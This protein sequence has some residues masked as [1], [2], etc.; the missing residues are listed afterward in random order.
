MRR[1]IAVLACLTFC[2]SLFVA[3]AEARG[4]AQAD[5]RFGELRPNTQM[6]PTAGFHVP[7][8]GLR[9]AAVA[10]TTYLGDWT[11]DSGGSIVPDGWVGVDLTAQSGEFWHVDDFAGLGGG[12]FGG[13]LP[14][15]GSQSM[16]CGA[17]AATTGPT[18][19]YSNA[20]GYG[21]NWDQVFRST[22]FTSLTGDLDLS[23]LASWDSEANWDFTYLEYD[24]CDDSWV[25]LASFDNAV[26]DSLVTVTI[27]DS[28]HAGSV[29]VRFRFISDGNTDDE[30]GGWN[31]DGPFI[32]DSL[33]VGD[34][35]GEVSFENFEVESV[36]DQATASGDWFQENLMSYGDFAGVY[37]GLFQVNESVCGRDL[38]G[39]WGFFNGSTANYACGGFPAQATVPYENIRG[40]YL[41]NEIWSPVVPFV[42]SGTEVHLTFRVYR[43]L[44]VDAL[45]FYVWN[46][47]SYVGGES[48]CPGSW[49]SD[50][51]V[52]YGP[53][54]DWL[55][56]DY[57]EPGGLI[58]PGATH[59]QVS[60]GCYDMCPYWCGIYGTGNCHSHSPLVDDVR[61]LRINTSGPQ[62]ETR[63]WRFFQDNFASDGTTTGTVRIDQANDIL[64][65]SNPNIR[66]GDSTLVKVNDPVYGL[67][68]D[69]YTS[70]GPAVYGWVSVRP[71]AVVAKRGAAITDD[72]SRWPVVDSTTGPDG[73]T[74]YIVRMDTVFNTNG[75]PISSQYCLDL[76]DNLFTPGDTVFYFL[77]AQSADGP[78]TWTYYHDA[79]KATDNNSSSTA[80]LTTP[81]I[82]VAY[83]N[84]M[85]VTCLPT[86]QNKGG[87]IL[88]VDHGDGRSVQP[89]F[90][91]AFEQLGIIDKVDRYDVRASASGIHNG[92]GFAVRDMFQQVLPIYRK[93]IWASGDVSTGVI[94]DGINEKHD[95]FE[96]L[97]NFVDQHDNNPGLYLTGEDVAE[98]WSGLAGV[99]AVN[100]KNAYMNFS[101]VAGDHK[102]V[103]ALAPLVIG[104]PG[105][106]FDGLLGPDTLVAYGGC[107]G[108]GAKFD[109]IAT[110]GGASVLEATYDGNSANGAVL[111]QTTANNA[112]STARII[113]EGFAYDLIRDDRPGAN[114]GVT[115]RVDHMYDILTFLQNTPGI[116]TDV[117]PGTFRNSLS[118]NYPN[119]FNPTTTIEF[120]VKER[121]P[122]NISIYNVAGQL[123]RTLVNDSRA[124]GVIHQIVWDGRNDAGQHAASGVYF[125]KLVTK[126]YTQTRKMVLLK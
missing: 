48:V 31:G 66:R 67:A 61:L 105:G 26:I 70:D 62:W 126:E 18:C 85:E 121:A 47:R 25:E 111:S 30:D 124:P 6:Q 10:D 8:G 1:T 44:T 40:Q 53:D 91:T 79:L 37:S 82:N 95:D 69:P 122:V 45:V 76:N 98:E 24:L 55:R 4:G 5:K 118:Q 107:P 81:D 21:H 28:L 109:I 101:L 93:I 16:W 78:G 11:F 94:S 60:I 29:R 57:N 19:G 73:Y 36:G 41:L 100:L 102:S 106:M 51:T 116:P 12:D 7:G 108:S 43:D 64:A 27:A 119:P 110:G 80:P 17:R 58:E 117:K 77:G 89:Y 115:D 125:Y 9:A 88:F 32:V 87:D 96:L 90:D 2:L 15:E 54:K 35:S 46:I 104:E 71:N 83:A 42:G 65:D 50:G 59:V 39:V 34:G 56:A 114:G 14:L 123:V 72:A 103:I 97:Y 68:L 38:T 63:P 20:P 120:T 86:V 113:L 22:C 52:W 99:N 23:F 33:R 92:P 13:L 3:I 49:Y 112:G 75:S 84:A 74:W